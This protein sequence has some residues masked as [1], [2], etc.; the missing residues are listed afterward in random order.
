MYIHSDIQAL[1]AVDSVIHAFGGKEHTISLLGHV[2]LATG[3]TDIFKNLS[4]PIT[5]PIMATLNDGNDSPQTDNKEMLIHADG[6]AGIIQGR[7]TQAVLM[8]GD[9]VINDRD[10]ALLMGMMGNYHFAGGTIGNIFGSIANNVGSAFNG[11]VNWVKQTAGNLKKYYDLATKIVIHPIKYVE[12]LFSW[13]NPKGVAGAMATLG[14][15]AFGKVENNVKNWRSALWSMASNNLDGGGASS[16]LLKAVEKYGEGKPHV[17]GATGADSFDCSG[18]VMYALK[19]AFG[20]NYPHFSGSQ[21]AMSQHISKSQ[22]HSGD[23]VFWGA[24]G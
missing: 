8:S 1:K 23:L 21:Y 17:W 11:A 3:T 5:K 6:S 24:G 2:K 22:A 7:N 19:K 4:S 12:S 20:I 18:L 14:K 16:A 10:T 9:N 15:D 13:S